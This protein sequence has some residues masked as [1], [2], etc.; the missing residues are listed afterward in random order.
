MSAFGTETVFVVEAVAV[1][2]GKSFL[3]TVVFVIFFVAVFFHAMTMI[4]LR[5]INDN[6]EKMRK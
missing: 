4:G 3:V 6:T 5:N 1:L 2:R